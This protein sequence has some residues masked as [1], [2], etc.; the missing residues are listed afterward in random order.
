MIEIKK[1]ITVIDIMIGDQ[2]RGKDMI[3]GGDQGRGRGKG[4]D[5]TIDTMIEEVEMIDIMIIDLIVDNLRLI[6]V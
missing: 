2:D 1:T 5:M 4:K 3:I 6:E